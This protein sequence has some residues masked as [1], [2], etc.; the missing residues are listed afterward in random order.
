M[1]PQCAR[2]R[3]R[4]ARRG[5]DRESAPS[6][7]RCDEHRPGIRDRQQLR[8]RRGR[9]RRSD[10]T[11]DARR[12]P[13]GA[14]VGRRV[15]RAVHGRRAHRAAS[16]VA[17]RPGLGQLGPRRHR[18]HNGVRC[19]LTQAGPGT[20]LLRA[21]LPLP[22][23][24]RHGLRGR[25]CGLLP[26]HRG[27]ARPR[28]GELLPGG[29]ARRG[30]DGRGVASAPSDASTARRHQAHSSIRCR[31]R[32]P[33]G[34][35]GGAPPIR[36]RS[37]GDRA[38][39]VTPYGGALRFRNRRRR[40]VLLRDG[41]AR[42]PRRRLA[43]AA[44]RAHPA[45]AGHLPPAPGVSLAVGGPVLWP[46][47]SRHQARE[48]LRL[49]LRRRIRLRKGAGFRD[50]ANGPRCSGDEHG[51]HAGERRSWNAGVHGPRAGDGDRGGRPRRYLCDR[52]RGLLAPD[53]AARIHRGHADGDA[54]ATRPDY[55]H[56]SVS[57]GG[58][59]DPQ[60]T[61]G[62]HPRLSGEGPRIDRS[63]P[64]TCRPDWPRS[65]AR[66]PGPR[67]GPGSGGPSTR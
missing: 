26:G 17:S 13:H 54:R 64:K 27:Q 65:R 3:R 1:G 23:R 36:A 12:R 24:C 56:T 42:R 35:H 2:D 67:T 52:L 28:A 43:P 25:S 29:K 15:G 60:A 21:D 37:P 19:H 9:I 6:A 61:R 66:A 32:A 8:H 53:R 40:R 50:R 44:L 58:P 34:V 11:R 30:R 7:Y 39:P 51:A 33:R 31:G 46:G 41:A 45:R 55:A 14:F 49:P 20:V 62:P 22:P 47:A 5:G 10:G 18:G 4:V 63:P 57:P 38:P 16:G 48:H 59:A